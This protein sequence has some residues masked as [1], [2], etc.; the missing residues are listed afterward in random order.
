[1]NCCHGST[2]HTTAAKTGK[3]I[4]KIRTEQQCSREPGKNSRSFQ[5]K[6]HTT[7]I[8]VSKPYSPSTSTS[9]SY[10]QLKNN[11]LEEP[12]L[13]LYC[14]IVLVSQTSRIKN[15]QQL[16][17]LFQSPLIHSFIHPAPIHPSKQANKQ[18][19]TTITFYSEKTYSVELEM[20][21]MSNEY[22]PSET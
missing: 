17:E 5:M 18:A 7:G 11:T 20:E 8:L 19:N 21:G 12:F 22:T 13:Y 10:S 15:I 14:L 4:E 16:E 3:F 2:D 9:A 6:S 1:M